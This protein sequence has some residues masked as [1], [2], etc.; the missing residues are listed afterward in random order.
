M[1]LLVRL[2]PDAAMI[3]STDRTPG[4][5]PLTTAEYAVARLV[6]EGLPNKHI[7]ATLHLSVKTVE[8]HVSSSLRKLGVTNRT[9][10]AHRLLVGHSAPVGQGRAI[11]PGQ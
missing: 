1:C 8:F 6:M 10:L 4:L 9:S 3:I 2:W 7:A 5:P 11:T